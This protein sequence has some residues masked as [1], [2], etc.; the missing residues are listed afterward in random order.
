MTRPDPIAITEGAL[1]PS[2]LDEESLMGDCAILFMRRSGPGGQNKNKVETA[3]I[4]EHRPTG[5]RAEANESRSQQ[6][7]RKSA[8]FRLRTKLALEAR[9][10]VNIEEPPSPLWN[11]RLKGGRI[12]VSPSHRDFP[13]LLA[14]ALDRIHVLEY[15]VKA[16]AEVLGCSTSQLVKFLK[17]EPKAIRLVNDQRKERGLRP[18]Q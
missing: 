10:S 14:E 7:N 3:V 16:A 15:D 8:V 12:Q 5:I 6:E 17:D 11:S 13:S 1:H 4:L 9:R 2:G 18:Y